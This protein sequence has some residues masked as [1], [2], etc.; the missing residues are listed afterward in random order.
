[1]KFGFAYE[2]VTNLLDGGIFFTN[3]LDGYNLSETA[4]SLL[5]GFVDHA[6]TALSYFMSE[7]VVYFVE[8]VFH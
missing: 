6:H 7:L 8:N 2:I 5:H 1:M 4:N 3:Q